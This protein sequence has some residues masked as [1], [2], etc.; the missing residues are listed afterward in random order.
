MSVPHRRE[1]PGEAA[2]IPHSSHGDS[3]KI[4]RARHYGHYLVQNQRQHGYRV[5][6]KKFILKVGVR[7]SLWDVDYA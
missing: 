1:T 4:Q 5:I 3:K 2:D 6:N 7:K